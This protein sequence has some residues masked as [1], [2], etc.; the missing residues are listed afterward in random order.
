MKNAYFR[1]TRPSEVRSNFILEAL[2]SGAGRRVRGGGAEDGPGFPIDVP[3]EPLFAKRVSCVCWLVVCT[4]S[5]IVFDKL[6]LYSVFSV[7]RT[8]NY[9]HFHIITANW[10]MLYSS[11]LGGCRLTGGAKGGLGIPVLAQPA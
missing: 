9:D 11:A 8:S 4:E 5:E 1:G 2:F 6:L 10:I 7:F 3:R